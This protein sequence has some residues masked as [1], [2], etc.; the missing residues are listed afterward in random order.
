MT[1]PPADGPLHLPLDDLVD[2]HCHGLLT[3]DL[4]RVVFESLMN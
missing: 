3:G 4:D 1:A 2:H